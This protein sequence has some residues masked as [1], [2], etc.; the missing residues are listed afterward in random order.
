MNKDQARHLERL[1]GL[2]GMP[3]VAAPVAEAEPA[4]E[5]RIYDGTDPATRKDITAASRQRLDDGAN[6]R[7]TGTAARG[8]IV[9][10]S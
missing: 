9:P 3:G 10:G 6:R 1:L 7:P 2:C 4:G 8:F 5:W